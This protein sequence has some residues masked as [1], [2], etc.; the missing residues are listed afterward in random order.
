MERV[1]NWTGRDQCIKVRV[2][3]TQDREDRYIKGRKQTTEDREGAVY[4]EVYTED[5]ENQCI[6]GEAGQGG[7]RV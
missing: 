2:V 6:K 7:S 5:R 4:K 1:Q 3:Y